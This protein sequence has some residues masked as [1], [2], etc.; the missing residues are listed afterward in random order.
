MIWYIFSLNQNG[1]WRNWWRDWFDV[2][3]ARSILLP[4]ASAL[5]NW[6]NHVSNMSIRLSWSACYLSGIYSHFTDTRAFSWGR[7]LKL[8]NAVLLAV[9]ISVEFPKVLEGV[10]GGDFVR[11]SQLCPHSISSHFFFHVGPAWNP[12]QGVQRKKLSVA[13]NNPWIKGRTG[14]QLS[15]KK[16]PTLWPII[17]LWGKHIWCWFFRNWQA[18][19]SKALQK[20]NIILSLLRLFQVGSK[21]GRS[22]LS[23]FFWVI[24]FFHVF[25]S[26]LLS[27]PWLSITADYSLRPD[28]N[29]PVC[30]YVFQP[31]LLIMWGFFYICLV[32][33]NLYVC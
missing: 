9:G 20:A 26:C 25:L 18:I 27:A 13:E 23:F 12:C 24:S 17:Y 6:C 15:R 28:F 30:V 22:L 5:H 32:F 7:A 11:T 33:L 3:I 4:S 14:Q 19:C 2:A 21:W 8:S 1:R 31:A 10:K 16:K 29:P